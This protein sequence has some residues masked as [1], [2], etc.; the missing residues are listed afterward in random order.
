MVA[1][2]NFMNWEDPGV[3]L[4]TGSSSGI[5]KEFAR[6]LANQGFNLI[7]IARR[8]EK[9]RGIAKDLEESNPVSVE[10]LVADLSKLSDSEMVISRISELDNLDVLINNAGFGIMRLFLQTEKNLH[11]GMINVHFTSPVLFCHAALPGMLKRKRGVI[12]NTSSMSA[13]TES[14]IFPMYTATKSAISVFTE[15]IQKKFKRSGIYFQ[16]LHPG[17]TITGFHST[18]YWKGFNRDL[19]NNENWM[20]AEEVVSLSLAAVKT[21]KI[22]FIPGEL[23]Q[24]SAKEARQKKSEKYLNCEVM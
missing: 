12:I 24:A 19:L 17:L 16:A 22:I 15:L 23:T 18:E 1:K 20:S 10:V 8:E 11:I 13:I 4:I 6:Q 21:K 9:L 14:P 2:S 7:L 5:G 3:A